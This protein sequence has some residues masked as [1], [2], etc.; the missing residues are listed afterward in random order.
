MLFRA[1]TATR[2]PGVLLLFMAILYL[3]QAFVIEGKRIM[4]EKACQTAWSHG[5]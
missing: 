5:M 4:D 2:Q 3:S 1:I